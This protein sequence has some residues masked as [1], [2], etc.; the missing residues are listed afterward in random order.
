MFCWFLYKCDK[1]QHNEVKDLPVRITRVP[2]VESVKY[3]QLTDLSKIKL[4]SLNIKLSVMRIFV[5]VM[6][7][8]G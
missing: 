4:P 1:K 7:K 6:D 3:P 8:S 2:V 5:K